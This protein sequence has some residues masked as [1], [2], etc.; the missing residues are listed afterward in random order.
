MHANGIKHSNSKRR[1]WISLTDRVIRTTIYKSRSC[2]CDSKA[3]GEQLYEAREK[4]E[5][6]KQRRGECG[7]KRKRTAISLLRTLSEKKTLSVTGAVVLQ[8]G[9]SPVL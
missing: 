4:K 7:R 3:E 8:N 5:E 6:A 2:T 1:G 9:R